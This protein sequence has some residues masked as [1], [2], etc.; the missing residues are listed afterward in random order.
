MITITDLAV[1]PAARRRAPQDT[2]RWPPIGGE[3][4]EQAI[5]DLCGCAGRQ[6][7]DCV[8]VFNQ[9]NRKAW[10]DFNTKDEAAA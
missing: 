5:D 9:A 7:C 6:D 10:G 4:I 1:L 3:K 2:L 8:S